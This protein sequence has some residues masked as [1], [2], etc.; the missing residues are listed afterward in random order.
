MADLYVAASESIVLGATTIL[1]PLVVQMTASNR[2]MAVSEIGISFNGTTATAVP[3]IVRLVRTSTAPATGATITQA[4]TPLDASSPASLCTAYM[5]VAATGAF[6]TP[7]TIGVTLRTWYV[8]PTSGIVIQF[9]LGNEPDSPP[10]AANGFAIGC[11]APVS[12]SVNAYMV[13]TE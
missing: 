3:V 4:A 5:P 12:V 13:W 1:T 7:P 6:G 9:P 2:R 10:T 8:P 11:L